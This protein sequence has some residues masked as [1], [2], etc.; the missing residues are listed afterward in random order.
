MP[1]LGAILFGIWKQWLSFIPLE[2][3]AIFMG[4]LCTTFLLVE[5]VRDII[6]AIGKAYK[7]KK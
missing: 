3:Y 7:D 2:V 4:A 6:I 5:G 1:V